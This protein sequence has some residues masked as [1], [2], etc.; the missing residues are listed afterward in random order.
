MSWNLSYTLLLVAI[1]VLLVLSAFLALAETSLVRTSKAKALSMVDEE[2][3]GSKVLLGLVENPGKFLNP[4]IFLVLVCQL[5]AATLVGVLSLKLF[6]GWGVL[7]STIAEVILFFVLAEAVP[8]TW[9]VENSEKAALFV[10]PLVNL[11]V[12]FPPVSL[13][14]RGLI[15]TAH[16]LIPGGFKGASVD[17]T[18][19]ELLAMA[20]VAMEEEVI[21]TQERALIHSIIEFGDTIVREVMVPRPD[22]V[23]AQ[24]TD[25]VSAVLEKS[26]VVG[27]SR[28]P[29]FEENI[30]NIIGV[31]YAK[32]LMKADHEGAGSL[33][34]GGLARQAHHIPET[35]RVA[36]L[37]REMQS[38]KFH[39]AIVVDEYGGT[40]GL[41]T[42]EDLIEELVGEIV[43]EFD[44][45]EPPLQSLG[46]GEWL[47]NAKMIISQVNEL[48]GVNLPEGSWDTLGG[49]L[50]GL[51]GHVPL[52]GEYAISNDCRLVVTKVQGRRIARVRISRLDRKT[53]HN[54]VNEH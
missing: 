39:Q 28:I 23:A 41:V 4:I 10:A 9:A 27:F 33:E 45:E 21:D 34:V 8:K 16:F 3:R 7:A 46:G 35:K 29:V 49:L 50:F 12:K 42:L 6:G 38:D 11:A 51:L 22:M 44:I 26:I 40:A 24:N 14:T 48:L 19:A 1:V 17:V 18:E 13:L 53:E 43:D 2:R 25:T 30:D 32:D 5:V 15:K 54:S 20:D 37:M 47:L 31:A 52:E 36:E